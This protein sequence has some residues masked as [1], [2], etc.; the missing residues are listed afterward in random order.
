MLIEVAFG[1]NA[2]WREFDV[3]EFE[4]IVLFGKTLRTDSSAQSFL[5]RT[6]LNHPTPQKCPNLT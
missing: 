6:Y 1:L 5:D 4:S 2:W 3:T